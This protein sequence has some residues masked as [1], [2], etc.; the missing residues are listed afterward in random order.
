[1]RETLKAILHD[2]PPAIPVASLLEAELAAIVRKLLRKDP[3]QRYA[4]AESV[5]GALGGDSFERG[6]S[7]K[8]AQGVG[9]LTSIAVLPFQFLNEGTSPKAWSLGFADAL[10]TMLGRVDDLMVLPTAAILKYAGTSDPA[11]AG[12]ELGVRHVLH[13]NRPAARGPAAGLHPALRR[14]DPA[15]H[16]LRDVRLRPATCS[17]CGMRSDAR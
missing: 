14:D 6:P 12:S 7:A 17:K 2:D 8:A 9:E 15:D 11:R 5:L 3:A 16:V 1:V 13:G 10:I 4:S